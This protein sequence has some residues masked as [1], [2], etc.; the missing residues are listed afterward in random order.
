MHGDSTHRT[1]VVDVVAIQRG[2]VHPNRYVIMSGDID[3]RASNTYDDTTDAP[4]ANDNASGIAGML[5]AARLLTRYDFGSSIVYVGLSGEEQGLWGGEDLAAKAGKEGWDIAAML[6]NDMIGNI[7]GLDGVIGNTTFRVFS[8]PVPVGTTEADYRRIRY[9]GG[10]VDGPSRE[11]ARYIDRVT[12]LYFTNLD[13]VMVYRLD[14][15]GR[16][17]HHRPFNDAGFPA[18]R[19]ME[20]HENYTR[21]HQNVRVENGIKYGDVI[22]GVNFEY[23]AK[24]AALN[25]TVLATL[26]W[27]PPSPRNVRIGGA[28]QPSTTLSW[29]AVKDPNLAGYKIYWRETT[30][31]QWQESR[32]VGTATE[33]TLENVV[34]D[35][36]LFGVAAVGKDGNESVVSFPSGLI[37][38]R[39]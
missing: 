7:E 38:G 16:G 28:V 33:Y 20:A 5:E 19:V 35:N 26:G 3:S 6:N 9:Y 22:E 14:R 34:I 4:G 11:L 31:P 30:A 2:K 18:V 10:E 24:M 23:V 27:A 8:E 21:Q 25:A 1:N 36:Y 32:Y 17:G 29:D 37:R 12:S 13:A 15:F 39:R